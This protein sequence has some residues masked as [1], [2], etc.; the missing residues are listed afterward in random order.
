M[1]E[2]EFLTGCCLEELK[3]LIEDTLRG[4]RAD[5]PIHEEFAK[6]ETEGQVMDFIIGQVI[7]AGQRYSLFLKH[8]PWEGVNLTQALKFH[9]YA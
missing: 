3:E 9:R 6:C 7:E 5:D 8:L 4:V 2:R 1:R